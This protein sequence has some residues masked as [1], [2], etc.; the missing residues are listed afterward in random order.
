MKDILKDEIEKI[1][2]E[3]KEIE[4]IEKETE[5][6]TERIRKA[7]RRK[8]IKAE[9]FLGGSL[10]KGTLIKKSKYD[11]DIF[12]RFDNDKEI[13]NILQEILKS[14]G[15]KAERIH[16]SRDYYRT[17]GRIMFEIV[18]VLRISSPKKAKNITDLSYF[19]VSYILRKTR[20]N[21]KLADE[22]ILAKYFCYMNECYGAESYI[23][24]F[25]GYAL[26]LL[27]SYYGS[28]LRFI[29][30]ISRAKQQII[31]DP[32]K[33]YKNRQDILLNLNEAKLSSPIVFVDP[34]FRERNALAA[35]S[36]E[37]FNKFKSVCQKFLK[38]QSAN[39]FKKK[40]IDE[41]KFNLIINIYTN[42]QAGD[43]AGSK[44]FKFFNFL[45]NKLEKDFSVKNKEFVYDENKKGKC[46]F[47]IKQKK[48]ILQGPPIN[49]VENL[50]NFKAKHKN[51]FIKRGIAYA[52]EKSRT[53]KEFLSDLKNDKTLKDMNVKIM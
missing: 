41:K 26:E 53:V 5:K 24:G 18:P 19:H 49:K 17:R 51:V 23:R 39:F 47:N 28:F 11:I 20:K 14:A 29:K 9:V 42:R 52:R 22:I 16:G 43:I 48:I 36:N 2:P 27:V 34:T 3:R 15:I 31:I 35:L 50:M 7:I 8:K 10:A 13:S 21:K 6:I 46:Y 40:E 32:E 37:T 33:H 30:T 1:K 25:S 45:E 44:L 12:I 38:K 4:V